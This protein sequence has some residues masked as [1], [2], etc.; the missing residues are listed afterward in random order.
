MAVFTYTS[1]CC[2]A[3]AS[4]PACEKP[5]AAKKGKGKTQEYATLG[6]WSCEKCGRACKVTRSGGTGAQG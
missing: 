5:K 2:G 4:K 3:A 6:H 1:V